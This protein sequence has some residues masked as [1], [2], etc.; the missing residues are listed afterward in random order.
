MELGRRRQR[1]TLAGAS[2]CASQDVAEYFQPRLVA[3]RYIFES[4]SGDRQIK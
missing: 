1:P 2:L 4:E 3:K